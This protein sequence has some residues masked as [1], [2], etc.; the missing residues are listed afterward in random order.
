VVVNQTGLQE[1]SADRYKR[2]QKPHILSEHDADSVVTPGR[3]AK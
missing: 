2:L 3:R 1:L